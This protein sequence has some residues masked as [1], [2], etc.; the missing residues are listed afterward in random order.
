[1]VIVVYWNLL[2]FIVCYSLDSEIM[3]NFVFYVFFCILDIFN[4]KLHCFYKKERNILKELVS[5]NHL[6]LYGSC[7]S[8]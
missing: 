7:Q 8:K 3:G 5:L 2:V 4:E 6:C 1:M